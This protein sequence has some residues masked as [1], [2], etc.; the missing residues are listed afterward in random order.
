M[1]F[2]YTGQFFCQMSFN[3]GLPDVFSLLDLSLCI[4]LQEYY[5]TDQPF[6]CIISGTIDVDMSYH[7]RC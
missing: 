5:R 4:F 6:S 2:K 7:K 3:L 1:T